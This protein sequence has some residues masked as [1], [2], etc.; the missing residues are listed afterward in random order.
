MQPI[1]SDHHRSQHVGQS[2][3]ILQEWGI[4]PGTPRKQEMLLHIC[5]FVSDNKVLLL[6]DNYSGLMAIE[7][8]ARELIIPV[9]L[10]K[11]AFN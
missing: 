1:H 11:C 10:C 5:F 3:K 8:R 4:Y 2:G 6:S 9:D 7:C